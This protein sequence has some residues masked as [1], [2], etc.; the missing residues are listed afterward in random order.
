MAWCR[1][2]CRRDGGWC[3]WRTGNRSAPPGPARAGTTA[4]ARSPSRSGTCRRL[5]SCTCW[6]PWRGRS[7]TRSGP[8]HSGSC[9][10]RSSA[11]SAFSSQELRQ[12]IEALAPA[13]VVGV[14][15]LDGVEERLAEGHAGL[16]TLLGEGHGNQVLAPAL[17]VLLPGEGEHDALRLDD[18]AI[19]PAHPVFLALGRAD[20]G[21]IGAARA[22]IHGAMGRGEVLGAEPAHHVLRRAPGLEHECARRVEG[23]GDDDFMLRRRSGRG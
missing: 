19:D 15:L 22:E 6:C 8:R 18:L 9:R 14:A 13:F 5:S 11:W 23:A 3:G 2:A 16:V 20:A 17:A 10:D 7:R 4:P 12:A 1:S 21:A